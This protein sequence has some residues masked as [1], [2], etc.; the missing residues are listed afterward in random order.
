MAP[1]LATDMTVVRIW[2]ASSG[3]VLRASERP[4]GR[5]PNQHTQ[6]S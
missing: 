2:V 1:A 6:D 3:E 5:N 4:V